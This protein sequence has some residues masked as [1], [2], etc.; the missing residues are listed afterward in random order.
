MS[1]FGRA[2]GDLDARA[3]ARD[4]ETP[5]KRLAALARHDEVLVRRA[6]AANTSTPRTSLERLAQDPDPQVRVAVAENPAAT[7]TVLRNV[8]KTPAGQGFAGVARRKALLAVLDHPNV[9]PELL[10]RLASDDDRLVARRAE[11]RT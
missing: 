4:T 3:A 11:A 8:L 6:V 7:P 10:R 9:T 1:L 2:K 5:P